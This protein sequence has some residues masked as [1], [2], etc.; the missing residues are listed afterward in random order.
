MAGSKKKAIDIA[1]MVVGLKKIDLDD[2]NYEEM[3]T[4]IS[5]RNSSKKYDEKNTKTISLK[6][7]VKHD[8]AILE[9]LDQQP[10]KQGFIKE[11]L[12][13]ELDRIL[14]KLEE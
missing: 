14:G 1:D 9:L 4:I 13:K 6:L 7:N 2:I 3:K 8:A 12:K 5:R 11:L 10:N